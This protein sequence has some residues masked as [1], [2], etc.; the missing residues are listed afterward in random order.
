MFVCKI[1][2]SHELQKKNYYKISFCIFWMIIQHNK[3]EWEDKISFLLA[4]KRSNF[5]EKEQKQH[6]YANNYSTKS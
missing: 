2:L 1:L 5:I 3:S 4:K 6:S